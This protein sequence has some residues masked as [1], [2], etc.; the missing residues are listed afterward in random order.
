MDEAVKK[1]L[2]KSAE[3][4]TQTALDEVIAIAEVYAKSTTHNEID[5]KI[6]DAVK[7]LKKAFLDDLVDKIHVE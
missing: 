4:M 7:L 6:V 2:M 5:D 1:Q 3:K